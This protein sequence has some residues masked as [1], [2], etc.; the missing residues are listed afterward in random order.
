MLRKYFLEL[1]K[2][3]DLNWG[4]N[5]PPIKIIISNRIILTIK[6]QSS[7]YAVSKFDYKKRL[8]EVKKMSR[9]D[10]IELGKELLNE[11]EAKNIP[12][13]DNLRNDLEHGVPKA[14]VNAEKK[15][16]NA[17]TNDE[18]EQEVKPA[19]EATPAIAKNEPAE[20]VPEQDKQEVKTGA[21]PAEEDNKKATNEG[22]YKLADGYKTESGKPINEADE[23]EFM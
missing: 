11:L 1:C 12:V 18:A 3:A 4:Q 19:E 7:M 16:A 17:E 23:R 14:I 2:R 22:G 20:N 10:R 5:L 15:L 8:S 21:E 13:N 6:H 9:A